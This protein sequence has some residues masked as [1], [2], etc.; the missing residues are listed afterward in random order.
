MQLARCRSWIDPHSLVFIDEGW[1][2]TL[3]KMVAS[4][5]TELE[6]KIRNAFASEFALAKTAAADTER[7]L[8]QADI[9]K[10]GRHA[11]NYPVVQEDR[12][13]FRIGPKSPASAERR[14]AIYASRRTLSASRSNPLAHSM[15]A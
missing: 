4:Q 7:R 11:R 1:R 6:M 9:F 15:G 13:N 14:A 10:G 12:T 2:N 3:M 8:F 5:I